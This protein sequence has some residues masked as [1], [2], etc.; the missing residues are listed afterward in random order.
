M[1]LE[2]HDVDK[3]FGGLV[4]LQG[5]SFSVEHGETLG[6]MGANGAGKTTLF[7][8]I[9]GHQNPTRG[10]ILLEGQKINGMRP[11]QIS[12]LG[13]ARTFQIVRPFRGLSVLENVSSGA[14]YG[15]RKVRSIKRAD[16]LASAILEDVRLKD[17]ASDLAGSLTLAGFKRLELAKALATGPKVLLL[18]EVMA[19]L[20]PKEVNEAISIIESCKF[21]YGLTVVVIEHVMRALMRMCNRIV[22]LDH[23]EM[24]AEGDPSQIAKDENVIKAYLG[25][26]V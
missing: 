24:I 1:L 6:I 14:L 8:L 19:G 10:S 7:S 9:A 22:V 4:A 12:G 11:D 20:T 5:I 25:E 15:A 18:D 23:G 13:V 3:H 16:E 2:V 17:R 21:K 26:E